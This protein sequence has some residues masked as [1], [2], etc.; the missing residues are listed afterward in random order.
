MTTMSLAEIGQQLSSAR[1]S[2]GITLEQAEKDT[3]IRLKYLAAM[4]AG[5]FDVLPDDV[6]ARGFL[7]NYARYLGLDPEPLAY[8][9][10][11]LRPGGPPV[12]FPGTSQAGPHVLEMDLGGS[13]TTG[14]S[15]L[16]TGVL[17]LAT[18]VVALYYAWSQGFIPLGG[19]G[20]NPPVTQVAPPVSPVANV[21]ADRPAPPGATPTERLAATPTPRLSAA[22]VATPTITASPTATPSA[23]VTPTPT[24]TATPSR[25]PTPTATPVREIRVR[26]S[27]TDYTWL[28]V[29]VDGDK[30]VEG[31][32]DP[33]RTFTW[34][35]KT[36]EVRTGNAGGIRLEVN[37]EDLGTMGK[38]G[39]VRHW[40]FVIDKG[41]L[42]RVTPT[43]TPTPSEQ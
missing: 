26:A 6:I 18:L 11:A 12:F 33:D 34:V 28:R 21:T 17:V 36:V 14:F 30:V 5:D 13:E 1:E 31:I 35:G 9:F 16:V 40:I 25:T 42:K 10:T 23:T 38:E 43:A 19:L 39:E 2:R 7:R 32:V 27:L 4:E 8:A 24:H 15:G 37:G 29:L 41:R 3:R 20:I 22:V